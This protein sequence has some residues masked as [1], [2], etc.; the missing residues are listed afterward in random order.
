M[1]NR[2]RVRLKL[3]ASPATVAHQPKETNHHSAMMIAARRLT[4][5]V[6]SDFEIVGQLACVSGLEILQEVCG[7]EGV[8]GG[9]RLRHVGY[10]PTFDLRQER[11]IGL[12]AADDE[13]VARE[14]RAQRE[15][16]R[17]VAQEDDACLWREH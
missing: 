12:R 13:E 17:L 1:P 3:R 9:D 14:I 4:S 16:V 8:G 2:K 10:E 6:E 5:R 7:H 15:H 11:A